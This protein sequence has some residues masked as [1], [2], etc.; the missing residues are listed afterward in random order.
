M[1]TIKKPVTQVIKGGAGRMILSD[2]P[3]TYEGKKAKHH[4][5]SGTYYLALPKKG[6]R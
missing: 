5:G 6:K 4:K 3:F 1:K 2:H